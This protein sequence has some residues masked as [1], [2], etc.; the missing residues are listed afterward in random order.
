[1]SVQPVTRPG[2]GSGRTA[3]QPRPRTPKL[4]L[5]PAVRKNSPRTP[6]VLLIVGLLGFGLL[7]LL[8]L[9][10]AAAQGAFR[11]NA[12]QT[13]SSSLG[14]QEQAYAQQAAKLADPANLAASAA[15][16]GMGPGGPPR[17]LVPGQPKWL[18]HWVGNLFV[19][20]ALQAPKP[21][22]AA[23]VAAKTPKSTGTTVKPSTGASPTAQPTATG[24]TG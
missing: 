22:V 9:N 23:S 2:T 18:G 4:V 12:L 3:R 11:L 17:F 1:M 6:F 10:T 5:A 14:D 15:K 7:A 16:L 20:P 19:I 8:L 24:T 21:P 13:Q